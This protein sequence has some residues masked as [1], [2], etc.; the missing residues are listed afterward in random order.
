MKTSQ[1][2]LS[3]PLLLVIESLFTNVFQNKTKNFFN[4]IKRLQTHYN[5]YINPDADMTIVHSSHTFATK[6]NS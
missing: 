1:A 3:K 6:L 2:L 4:S 5:Q